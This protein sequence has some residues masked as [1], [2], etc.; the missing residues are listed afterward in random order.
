MA[1]HALLARI[2]IGEVSRVVLWVKAAELVVK[3][4][5]CTTSLIGYD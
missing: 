5:E 2:G 4:S 3:T 1:V